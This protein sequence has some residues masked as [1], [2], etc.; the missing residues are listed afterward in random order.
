MKKTTSET[1][2]KQS[3]SEKYKRKLL[4]TNKIGSSNFV[5][6]ISSDVH[7][8]LLIVGAHSLLLHQRRVQGKLNS[9]TGV[10]SEQAWTK[11]MHLKVI[12]MKMRL[13]L[14]FSPNPKKCTPSSLVFADAANSRLLCLGVKNL[15]NCT[16][17]QVFY[18]LFVIVSLSERF[19]F[20]MSLTLFF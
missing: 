6:S 12:M 11:G 13:I 16:I 7:S 17:V 10:R 15:Y 5:L 9:T 3:V 8:C 18:Y 14:C 2:A 20:S 19:L 1:N 4:T